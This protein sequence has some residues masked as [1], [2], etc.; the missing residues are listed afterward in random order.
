MDSLYSIC[1]TYNLENADKIGTQQ[2]VQIKSY[3]R[4][5]LTNCN[6]IVY[7]T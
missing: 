6:I 2:T 4:L 3:N 5:L 7:H 1:T